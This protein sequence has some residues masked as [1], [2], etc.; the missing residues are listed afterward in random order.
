MYQ[1]PEIPLIRE[2]SRELVRQLGLL[3]PLVANLSVTQCHVMVEL[4]R[5][6]APTIA[7]LARRLCVD[8]STMSRCVAKLESKNWVSSLPLMADKRAKPLQL[9]EAGKKIVNEIHEKAD[10]PVARALEILG[11]QERHRVLEGMQLY[12]RALART[13]QASDLTLRPVTPGDNKVLGEII[14]G[15]LAEFGADGPGSGFENEELDSLFE[16]YAHP[17]AAFFV[18]AKGSRVLGGGGIGPLKGGDLHTCELQKMYFLEECRGRGMGAR[19]LNRCLA[20]AKDAGYRFCYLETHN[21][22]DRAQRL[23]RR[24]GFSSMDRPLGKTGHTVCNTWFGKEL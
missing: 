8:K 12:S 3:Q 1:M 21:R 19:L 9:T 24:F 11:D 23:Y 20:F 18:I 4:E 16:A 2:A 17:K 7:T 10:G 5:E 14:R 6:E 22:M 13:A 15:V